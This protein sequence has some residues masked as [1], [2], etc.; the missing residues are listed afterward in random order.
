MND[1]TPTN[2]DRSPIAVI[3][4]G[5]N[6][7][8]QLI[9]RRG[10]EGA[11]EVLDDR[12]VTARLGAG[13][14]AGGKLM[15]DAVQ[16][17]VAIV[18]DL[19]ARAHELGVREQDVRAAGTAVLRRAADAQTFIDAVHDRTGLDIEV[20]SEADEGRLG[21]LAVTA[22][23][24]SADAW[25]VD[26]GGGST[27]IVGELGNLRL[28]APIGAITLSAEAGA[29]GGGED[30]FDRVLSAAREACERFPSRVLSAT[31]ELIAL[32]GTASN[33][34]CLDLGLAAY[35]PLRAEG[36]IV[37]ARAAL[38]HARRLWPLTAGERAW[39]PIEADRAEILPTGLICLGAAF[40]RLGAHR[41]RVSGR[42]LRFGM[43]R[44]RLA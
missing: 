22:D 9:A 42:G 12:C 40:E 14:K 44:E 7:I 39:L 18:A 35:D 10:S 8:L 30:S 29:T 13:L 6:T 36:H 27:E 23:G 28:S 37:E 11:L 5:T 24:A 16:R 25:I 17:S 26:V 2:P 4:V 38:D 20:L 33:L 34:A 41:A 32:G 19:L 1:P 31:S 43:A 15:P 3:D 21:F